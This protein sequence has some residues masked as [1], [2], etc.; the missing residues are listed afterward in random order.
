LARLM[1]SS[2]VGLTT[3]ARLRWRAWAKPLFSA[4]SERN[5]NGMEGSPL[6][7][8]L[9]L[10][11]AYGLGRLIVAGLIIQWINSNVASRSKKFPQIMTRMNWR[12]R[13]EIRKH[14]SRVGLSA[15][16]LQWGSACCSLQANSTSGHF[17]I[18]GNF[19]YYDVSYFPNSLRYKVTGPKVRTKWTMR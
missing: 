7:C 10:N 9:V 1:E 5:M 8:P 6:F 19:G 16:L 4:A 14:C 17:M 11:V 12:N 13:G 2:N 15:T 18:K 3:L